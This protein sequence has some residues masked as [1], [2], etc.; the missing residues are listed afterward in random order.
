MDSEDV[1][2]HLGLTLLDRK[3]FFRLLA[4]QKHVQAALF[5]D[6]V[7][8]TSAALRNMWSLAVWS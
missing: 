3:K 2:E 1:D 6:A 4:D 7:S 8:R 5:S